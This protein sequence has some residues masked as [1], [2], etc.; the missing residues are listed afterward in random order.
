LNWRN[1]KQLLILLTV[2]GP[3]LI[4]FLIFGYIALPNPSCT[5]KKQNQ[6]ETGADCGGPCAPCELKNPKSIQIFWVRALPLGNN[7]YDL[8]AFIQNINEVLSSKRLEYEFILSDRFGIILQKTGRSF[9]FS[10]DRA[11]V[12]ESNIKTD[13]VPA[14]VEFK[15]VNPNWEFKAI[16]RPNIVIGRKDYKIEAIGEK[17]MS[18]VETNLIN[19]TPFN[20]S[21]TEVRVV[22]FDR[23]QNVL[24][25]SK[26]ILDNFRTGTERTVKSIW[27]HELKGEIGTIEV[28]PRANILDSSIALPQ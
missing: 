17:K 25:V 23:K 28:E 11:F 12:I 21:E 8:A 16:E 5:D 9:I 3:V 13:R 4:L 15:I 20:L 6:G 18:V 10:Q 19:R 1:K 27:P 2:L 26:I 22:V 7:S 24:G 14:K